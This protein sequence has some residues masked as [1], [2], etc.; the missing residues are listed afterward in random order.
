MRLQKKVYQRLEEKNDESESGRQNIRRQFQ[1]S[2]I[3]IQKLNALFDA[4]FYP[5]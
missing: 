2:M 3:I 5:N 1:R 4:S